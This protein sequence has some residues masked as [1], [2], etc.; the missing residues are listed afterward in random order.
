[1]TTVT[2]YSR[3][4]ELIDEH[5]LSCKPQLAVINGTNKKPWCRKIWLWSPFDCHI[6]LVSFVLG[7]KFIFPWLLWLRDTLKYYSPFIFHYCPHLLLACS[8][9]L[10]RCSR[11]WLTGLTWRAGPALLLLWSQVSYRHCWVELS[12]PGLRCKP[13]LLPALIPMCL[14]SCFGLCPYPL[15]TG[16]FNKWEFLF[17]KDLF[18][19]SNQDYRNVMWVYSFGD[20]PNK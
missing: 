16:F 19:A 11:A 12:P 2:I 9:L 7:K 20:K 5:N 4:L 13:S 8:F 3:K 18:D 17:D 6:S 14:R 1:M 10:I 15:L